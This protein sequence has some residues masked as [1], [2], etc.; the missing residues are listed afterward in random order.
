MSFPFD[1]EEMIGRCKTGRLRAKCDTS[2]SAGDACRC[3]LASCQKEQKGPIDSDGSA[4][5]MNGWAI[6]SGRGRGRQA[7]TSETWG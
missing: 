7:A 2:Q 5:S 6:V 4:T 3:L 1:G